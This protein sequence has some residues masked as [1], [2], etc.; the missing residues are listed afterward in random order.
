MK[1]GARRGSTIPAST[2][3][4]EDAADAIGSHLCDR[5]RELRLQKRW[6][7][8]QL[9]AA[10][11]VSRSMLSQIERNQANPTLGVALRIAQAFHLSVGRLVDLHDE[12]PRMDVIRA[13]DRAYTFN[14]GRH[15]SVR[16][17]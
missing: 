14:S 10:S 12:A 13:S 17:L 2:A 4:T 1:Q 16:T 11:G 15:C 5:V 7:L 8:Q 9:S 6:T 3:T